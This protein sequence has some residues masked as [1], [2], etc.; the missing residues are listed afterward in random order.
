ML[1]RPRVLARRGAIASLTHERCDGSGYHRGLAGPAIPMTGSNAQ[2]DAVARTLLEAAIR[3]GDRA[4][5]EALV[6]ERLALRDT[7]TYNRRQLAR[8]RAA[9]DSVTTA[10]GAATD[11]EDTAAATV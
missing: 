5:G 3:G 11:R 2:R 6:F 1:A 4:L 9:K 10:G 8:V 7:S